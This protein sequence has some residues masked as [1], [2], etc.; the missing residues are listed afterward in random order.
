MTPAEKHAVRYLHK[1]TPATVASRNSDQD[2]PMSDALNN[3][4]KI[5]TNELYN[6]ADFVPG[7]FAE[8]WRTWSTAKHVLSD[9]RNKR[10]PLVFEAVLCLNY[11]ERFWG[12][13]LVAEAIQAS[14]SERTKKHLGE[15]EN[16]VEFEV[17]FTDI[18]DEEMN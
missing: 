2:V 8:V 3:S 5:D 4:I 11:D 13:Q 9:K 15:L 12:D 14:V 1:A 7:S 17:D 6:C 10:K 16:Q 18:S